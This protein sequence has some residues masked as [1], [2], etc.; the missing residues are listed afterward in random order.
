[1]KFKELNPSTDDRVRV[2]HLIFARESTRPLAPNAHYLR[3]LSQDACGNARARTRNTLA[4]IAKG[5]FASQLDIFQSRRCRETAFWIF[6]IIDRRL[7][8]SIVSW[9]SAI[10][11]PAMIA[12]AS[13]DSPIPS[14]TM[15]SGF[16]R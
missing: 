11:P 7:G 5:I 10:E 6:V 4:V 14:K 16:W 15:K 13:S 9:L 3:G 12:Q 1:M 8:S 2:A